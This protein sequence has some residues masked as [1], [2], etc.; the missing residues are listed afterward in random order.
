MTTGVLLY[1]VGHPFYYRLAYNLAASIWH[2]DPE[3][4]VSLVCNPAKAVEHL[5]EARAA[6]FDHLVDPK[7]TGRRA[8][9]D[10]WLHMRVKLALHEITPYD[11]T[12]FVDADSI[13]LLGQPVGRLLDHLAGSPVACI[14]RTVREPG[15]PEGSYEPVQKSVVIWGDAAD[16]EQHFGI[17]RTWAH[18][19]SQVT[20]RENTPE[21]LAYWRECVALHDLLAQELTDEGRC[22]PPTMVLWNGEVCDEPVM[23]VVTG[24]FGVLPASPP[25]DLTP[26]QQRMYYAVSQHFIGADLP[27]MR[28]RAFFLTLPDHIDLE[29]GKINTRIAV[30][31]YNTEITET[32]KA[33]PE[34]LRAWIWDT[35]LKQVSSDPNQL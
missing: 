26:K 28:N 33:L 7:D 4:K 34:H 35:N 9:R 14:V 13:N 29:N 20:Y 23:S 11:R 1:A 22:G 27:Y 25:N 2:N 16:Y 21:S 15:L 12:L 17:V 18:C 3:A 32:N 31:F 5:G 24:T 30:Q 10:A 6:R 19:I 8:G